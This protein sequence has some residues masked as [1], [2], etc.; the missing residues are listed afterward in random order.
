MILLCELSF[1]GRAHV[2][3]NAGLLATIRLAFPH[4]TV[5]FVAAPEHIR[6]LKTVLDQPLAGSIAWREVSPPAA[7]TGYFNRFLQE[8]GI[9]WEL[10]KVLPGG[11]PSRLLLT[12][13]YPSTVLALK[14]ARMVGSYKTPVQVILHGLSGVVGKRYRHPMRKFQDMKTAL[15]VLSNDNIQYLVLEQTIRQTVLQHLPELSGRVEALEHPISPDE[16]ASHTLDL[17]EPIRFGFLGLAD[18]AKGFPLFVELANHIGKKYGRRVEFHAIGHVP[19]GSPPVNGVEVLQTKPGVTLMSRA[20]FIGALAPI[21]FVVL[22]HETASYI[23]TAS[24]VVLDAIAWEKPVIARNMPIFEAMFRKFGDIGY[25]FRDGAELKNVVE[26]IVQAVDKT[27]YRHQALNL[28]CARK[29]REPESL[30]ASYREIC[31]AC[32]VVPQ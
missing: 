24:G 32:E 31:E 21:H 18:T 27:R 4:E 25:M 6:E 1:L 15:T 29:S 30:A 23:L 10:L 28:R 20:E 5:S 13:A 22:P 9:I 8:L 3:F 26:Q 16:G 17:T 2:P 19:K 7:G 11:S 12:S 14:V